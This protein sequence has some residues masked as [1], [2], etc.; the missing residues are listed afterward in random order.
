MLVTIYNQSGIEKFRFNIYMRFKFRFSIDFLHYLSSSLVI[1]KTSIYEKTSS[2]IECIRRNINEK[3]QI[4]GSQEAAFSF[5]T[6]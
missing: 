3:N 4:Q 2:N 5:L 1:T 6:D